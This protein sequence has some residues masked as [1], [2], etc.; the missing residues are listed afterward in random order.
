MRPSVVLIVDDNEELVAALQGVL[1]RPSRAT[2]RA[3]EIVTAS[4]GAD[5]L[6]VARSRGVDVAIVDVKLPDTSGVDLIAPLKEACPFSEVV[7]ITGSASMDAALAALRS[8]AFAFVLKSFRPEELISTVEQ[9]VTKVALKREREEL[10]RRYRAV[11][12][13]T[14]VLAIALDSENA[15]VL[16]NRRAAQLAGTEAAHAIGRSFLASWIPE[17]DRPAL[18]EAIREARAGGRVREVEAG[19]VLDGEPGTPLGSVRR[20]RWHLSSA[21]AASGPG[22][23]DLDLVY[24]IGIDVTE[25]RLLEKRAADA[26]ALSAMGSLAMNLAHEIRNPLN[27]AVLQLHLLDKDIGK[28]P[29]DDGTRTTLHRRTRIVGDEIGRLNRL[30]TEFLELARPRDIAHEPVH[31]AKLVDD[32]LDLERA[33]ADGAGVRIERDIAPDGCVAIGDREKLKQVVLNLVVNALEAMRGG[34][35]LTARVVPRPG[36]VTL[37]IIDTGVGI[38]PASL[39]SIFDPFFTTK[40]GGT[41]LGLSI[42]R[43]VVDRHHGRVSIESERGK[44]T[45][46]SVELPSR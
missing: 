12:Q 43:Q 4:R 44:G 10:E 22:A 36:W 45:T 5:A 9:A 39:G 16:F 42:V 3:L 20:V 7:L 24:G 29:V 27:A 18:L 28:L 23:S 34:G 37:S 21:P 19:F 11:V 30:L 26:E 25:R 2:E 8:G 32:V 13:L 6:A 31:L 35:T 33:T 14:D 46:V 41:G 1:G 38:E 15:V 40:E 17:R